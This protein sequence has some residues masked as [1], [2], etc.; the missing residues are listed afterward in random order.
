[1]GHSVAARCV[2]PGHIV[3]EDRSSSGIATLC[4]TLI[5]NCRDACWDQKALTQSIHFGLSTG[6]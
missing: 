2:F 4:D 3:L 1:M 6:P 5:H